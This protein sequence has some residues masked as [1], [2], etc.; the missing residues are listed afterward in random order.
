MSKKK[1]DKALENPNFLHS[2]L[3][4]NKSFALLWTVKDFGFG[5]ISFYSTNDKQ[6]CCAS[7]YMGR[8][9][10][11]KALCVMVDNCQFTQ[12]GDK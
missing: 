8:E 10:V 9:F 2:T 1:I 4:E 5:E 12:I 3:E 6:M 7:E 11:K